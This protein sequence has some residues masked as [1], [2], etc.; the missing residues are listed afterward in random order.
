MI[1]PFN[2]NIIGDFNGEGFDSVDSEDFDPGY[3]CVVEEV[4]VIPNMPPEIEP[5]KWSKGLQ[6]S[7]ELDQRTQAEKEAREDEY[8]KRNGI[9]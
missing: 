1:P 5:I 3:G 7:Y 6:R 8:L 4:Q 2:K 9:F